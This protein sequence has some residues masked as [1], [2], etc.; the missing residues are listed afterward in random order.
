[1]EDER[2]SLVDAIAAKVKKDLEAA[3]V[4]DENIEE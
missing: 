4:D 1:M 2:T 3:G